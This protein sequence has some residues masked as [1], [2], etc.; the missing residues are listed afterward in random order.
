MKI[1]SLF[2]I[3]SF[4]VLSNIATVSAFRG[5]P[6]PHPHGIKAEDVR[7]VAKACRPGD[8]HGCS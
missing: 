4:F 2:I 3:A 7:G 1:F 6:H 8:P 5:H